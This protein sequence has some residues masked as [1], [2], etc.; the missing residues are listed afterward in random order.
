MKIVATILEVVV[1]TPKDLA[2]RVNTSRIR[3][4]LIL[5][6]AVLRAKA[7]AYLSPLT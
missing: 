3:L 7:S 5:D 6:T 4:L 1:E 2:H